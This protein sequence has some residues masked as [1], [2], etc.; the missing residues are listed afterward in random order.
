VAAFRF[1]GLIPT[2]YLDVPLTAHPADGEKPATVLA[3]PAGPPDGRWEATDAPPNQLPDNAPA[4]T[5][6][7]G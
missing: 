2:Q 5:T 6:P 4:D 3:W 1:T 7:E